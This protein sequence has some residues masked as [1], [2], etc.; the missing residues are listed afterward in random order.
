MIDLTKVYIHIAIPAFNGMMHESCFISLLKFLIE[1]SKHNIA[2]TLDTMGNESL[3]TRARNNLAGKF[4]HNKKATHLMFIDSDIRFE[5]ED[6]LKLLI[7]DKDVC[8]G[9]Y[10][11]KKLPAQLVINEL[12]D[13]DKE[14]DLVEV[15]TAGTGFMLIKRNV[16]DE[17]IVKYPKTKYSE[18]VGL[19]KQYEPFLYALFDTEI[20][21][22]GHYLSEDWTFCLRWR[23]I[24]GK[25][26]VHKGIN[27][28]HIGQYEYR[29][30]S[31]DELSD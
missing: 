31:S 2:W 27:L 10:P 1:A 8:C 16:F 11:V 19:G 23:A 15:S 3:I 20:S 26:W 4:L 12:D 21:T 13:G 29:T 14:G 5:P 30:H 24:G 7:A 9:A 28:G 25:V 6:I 17:M 22:E 18:H